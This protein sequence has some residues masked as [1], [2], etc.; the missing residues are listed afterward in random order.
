[1][2]CSTSS[3]SG[4]PSSTASADDA[5]GASPRLS[6]SEVRERVKAEN[7]DFLLLDETVPCWDAAF[8]ENEFDFHYDADLYFSFA[9]SARRRPADAIF[10]ALTDTQRHGYP[11]DGRSTCA[12]SRT[13]DEDRYLE[14]CGRDALPAA[15]AATFTLPGVPMIYYGQERDVE[16]SRG[17]M[18]WY[19]GDQDLTD[20]HR[21]LVSLRDDHPAI[22]TDG[23]DPVDVDVAEGDPDSVVAYERASDDER[24]VVVLNFGDEPA[25]VAPAVAVDGTDLLSETDVADGDSLRVADAVVPPAR[26]VTNETSRWGTGRRGPARLQLPV[27]GTERAGRW[28]S[29]AT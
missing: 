26:G 25:T 2:G 11:D 8:H 15:A 27:G 16:D 5:H 14:E 12:T 23:V 9:I 21:R 22:R 1:V 19:D 6:G 10:D 13:H 18:K 24:L 3:R 28:G 4:R 20:F 17:T 7:D 29:T